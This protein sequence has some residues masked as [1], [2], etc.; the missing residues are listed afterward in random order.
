MISE[1][2]VHLHPF[3]GNRIVRAVI[4]GF[5]KLVQIGHRDPESANDD[6]YLNRFER[7]LVQVGHKERRRLGGRR[8]C[9]SRVADPPLYRF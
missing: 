7:S 2:R 5:L 6:K 1:V 8:R 4:G 3:S 9:P